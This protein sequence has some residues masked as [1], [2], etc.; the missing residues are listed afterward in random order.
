MA[1]YAALVAVGRQEKLE[2][3]QRDEE[4]SE[5][6]RLRQQTALMEKMMRCRQAEPER[7][8]RD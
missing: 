2:H 1:W 5:E 6:L 7:S 8:V 3:K 4:E